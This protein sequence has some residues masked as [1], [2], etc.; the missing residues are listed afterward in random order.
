MPTTFSSEGQFAG[1]AIESTPGT[2]VAMSNTLIVAKLDWEDKP[3]WLDDTG[4]RGWFTDL[5][6]RQTGPLINEFSMSGDVFGDVLPFFLANLFGD[7]TGTGTTTTPTTALS[8]L[9]AAGATT[10]TT[11]ASIPA[12][13]VIQ[14][15]VGSLAEIRTTGTPSGAGPY[16]IPLAAGQRALLYG[17]AS[18]AAVTAVI[19]PFTNA[20]ALLN[21][22][23]SAPVYPGGQPVTNTI[24]HYSGVTATSGARQF[25][26]ACCS[27]LTLSFNAETELLKFDS[28]WV[29]WPSV[30]A[31][32]L[33][34]AAPS[35]VLP[36]ASWRG[37]LGFAGPASSGTQVRAV[38]SGKITIKRVCEPAWTVAGVQTPYIIQRGPLSISGEYEIIADAE[39]HY[40]YMTANTQPSM[41]FV[42]T[43]GLAG[44]NLISVQFDAAQAAIKAAKME[45]GKQNIR[46]QCQWDAIANV[47][48]AGASGGGSPGKV[49]VINAVAANTYQ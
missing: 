5:A 20:F 44:A 32:A 45:S 37:A 12:A 13:T 10:I 23:L 39:T 29:S 27:E 8:A 24:T 6:G 36:I 16:T 38:P 2:A 15:G 21:S 9:T 1:I 35:A 28:K 26:G 11:A 19:A 25:P 4:W 40:A 46:Y 17:H 3:K 34:T 18:A 7:L 47:T 49:T 22:S 42:I 31:S 30:A 48:N 33:P 14:I 41:Q 43:N